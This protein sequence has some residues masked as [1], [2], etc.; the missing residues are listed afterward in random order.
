MHM[1]KVCL[2]RMYV[3]WLYADYYTALVMC[4]YHCAKLHAYS[5]HTM[6]LC[7]SVFTYVSVGVHAHT[8]NVCQSVCVCVR[9]REREL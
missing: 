3:E 6:F 7:I 8:V 5:E 1:V 4:V 9:E 2:E